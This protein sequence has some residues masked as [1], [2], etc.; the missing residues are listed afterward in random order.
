M[1]ESTLIYAFIVQVWTLSVPE[2]A[3]IDRSLGG[4]LEVDPADA[5]T[6]AWEEAFVNTAEPLATDVD[7]DTYLFGQ[8]SVSVDFEN[9]PVDKMV[10][11]EAKFRE[12]IDG[13]ME[14]GPEAFDLD[15]IHTL[16]KRTILG[17]KKKLE[18]SPHLIIPSPVILDMI[19]GTSKDDLGKFLHTE[20]EKEAQWYL[21]Q[22]AQ[23][24]RNEG[25]LS[26]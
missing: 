7:V 4:G 14:A 26:L 6:I 10:D 16:I 25:I 8:P 2:D 11:V 12:V 23:V 5:T 24:L 20:Q 15:R 1:V 19:Y 9:V 13:I 18:N 17:H 3:V 21:D 22:P